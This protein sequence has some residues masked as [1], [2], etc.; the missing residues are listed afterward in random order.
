[1]A[2]NPD[3][4]VA[5]LFHG[6]V[7]DLQHNDVARFE[8]EQKKERAARDALRHQ[9]PNC[10]MNAAE[11]LKKID[12]DPAGDQKRIDN[13]LTRISKE[14]QAAVDKEKKNEPLPIGF[15]PPPP[16]SG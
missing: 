13:E 12:G 5:L 6:L 7:S 16:T 11:L 8:E 4:Q 14:A 15:F 9:A 3:E 1:M 2:D 10:G